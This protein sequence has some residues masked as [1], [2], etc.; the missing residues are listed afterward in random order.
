[1]SYEINSNL[2]HR[3]CILDK[4]VLNILDEKKSR[5]SQNISSP[6]KRYISRMGTV[7]I[8]IFYN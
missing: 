8:H 2:K 5:Y 1:M 7:K 4:K 6:L 3:K